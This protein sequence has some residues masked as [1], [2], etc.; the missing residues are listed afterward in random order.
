MNQTAV[1]VLNPPPRPSP[2]P[3]TARLVDAFLSGRNER[4][5]QAYRQDLEDFRGFVGALT[6]DEAARLLLG[7]G[8][9]E[10][11]GIA[12]QGL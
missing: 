9:G 10:A 5:L 7:W 8:H 2:G 1:S 4:T 6:L 12:G 3:D 11:N